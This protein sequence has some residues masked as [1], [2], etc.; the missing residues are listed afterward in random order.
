MKVGFSTKQNN[1]DRLIGGAVKCSIGNCSDDFYNS[2]TS[3][4][5]R[6]KDAGIS[7]TNTSDS[8]VPGGYYD[9]EGADNDREPESATD[10]RGM[11][12]KKS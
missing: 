6:L 9:R 10:K 7:V 1:G 8:S 4:D 3:A 5:S 11:S 2:N 12:L